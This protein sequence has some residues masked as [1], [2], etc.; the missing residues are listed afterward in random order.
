MRRSS[1]GTAGDSEFGA[2]RGPS[3]QAPAARPPSRTN[4][5]RQ[6]H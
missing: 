4:C 1:G 2:D 3:R 5:R 6:P